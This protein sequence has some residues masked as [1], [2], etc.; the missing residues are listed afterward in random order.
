MNAP[1]EHFSIKLKDQTLFRQ[2]CY[3][4][5]QWV[6]ADGRQTI[7][8]TNPATGAAIGTVP[9]MGAA[10]ARRAIEAADQALPGWRVK[11]AKERATIVTFFDWAVVQGYAPVSPA[12]DLVRGHPRLQGRGRIE[13]GRP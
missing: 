3:I 5:G 12:A 10:E 6:D 7:A 13:A 11:T 8:V 2:Q 4:D 1:T 9:R